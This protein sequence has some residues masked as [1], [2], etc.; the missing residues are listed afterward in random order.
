MSPDTN[1]ATA[2][3]TALATQAAVPAPRTAL[4]NALRLAEQIGKQLKTPTGKL[5]RELIEA[6]FFR[7]IAEE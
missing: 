2:K 6:E 7:A 4:D 5:K 3:D 1:P